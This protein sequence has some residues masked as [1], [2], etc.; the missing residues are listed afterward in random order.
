[1]K[2]LNSRKDLCFKVTSFPPEWSWADPPLAQSTGTFMAFPESAIDLAAWP[3][4]TTMTPLIG[5]ASICSHS[6]V[7]IFA[8]NLI[9]RTKRKVNIVVSDKLVFSFECGN[10]N[11][12]ESKF[13]Y[14]SHFMGCS[15][16][17]SFNE[18]IVSL[19]ILLQVTKQIK[20]LGSV[21]EMKVGAEK[22]RPSSLPDFLSCCY[23]Q[24][25]T[26]ISFAR[27]LSPERRKSLFNKLMPRKLFCDLVVED[28][29][30]KILG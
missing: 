7:S 27:A 23:G 16:E 30:L 29:F 4:P 1:M 25:Q 22:M 19:A 12:V 24:K 15:L 5:I 6:A 20:R 13:Y 10:F 2:R 28:T 14:F 26:K 17:A 3:S 21:E 18:P 8:E 11:D 9:K